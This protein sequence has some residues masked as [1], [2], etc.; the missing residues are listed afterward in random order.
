MNKEQILE[1]FDKRF[2]ESLDFYLETDVDGHIENPKDYIK[3]IDKEGVKS[4]LLKAL[5]DQ[6]REHKQTFNS[7]SSDDIMKEYDKTVDLHPT[8]PLNKMNVRCFLHK[9]LNTHKLALLDAQIEEVRRARDCFDYAGFCIQSSDRIAQL[10]KER[11]ALD[12]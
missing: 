3:E 6:E 9:I 1:E 8:L 10:K 2:D 7:N 4:F 5:E 11:E 12:G